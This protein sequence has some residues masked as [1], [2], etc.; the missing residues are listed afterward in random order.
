LTA[1]GIGTSA[2]DYGAIQQ[3]VAHSVSK[4]FCFFAAG[5]VLLSTGTREIAAVRGL[6]HRS[7]IAGAALV[8]GGLAITGAPPL[9]IFLSEFSILKA[10]L[11][12]GRYVVTG[13]LALF[14]IIAFFGVMLHV[15][16]IVFGT[17][18]PNGGG[19]PANPHSTA[20][21]NKMFRLPVSCGFA[22]VL[23]AL[24]VLLL[25]VYIPRPVHDLLALAAGA[26]TR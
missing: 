17:Q 23:A 5:A 18:E 7:P 3:I 2:G 4:S 26:L 13:L 22:L 24:P 25:G 9:A 6:I 16:R 21:D 14:I 11:V 1:V 12:Q 20:D 15:N 8:L 10:G 19:D